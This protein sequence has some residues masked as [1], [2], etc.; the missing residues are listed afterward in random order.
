MNTRLNNIFNKTSNDERITTEDALILYN[1]ADLADLAKMAN[2]IREKKFGK[3]ATF[4]R[5]F[6]IEPTNICIYQC[7]FCSYHRKEGEEGSW[8]LSIDEMVSRA[9]ASGTEQMSEVHIVGAVYKDWDIYF[10][11]NLLKRIRQARPNIHIKAFSAVEISYMCDAV[12]LDLDEGL[13][14][15]KESGLDSIPGGG[16]EIFEPSIRKQICPDKINGEDWLRVHETAHKNGIP[17]NATMLY[18]HIENYSHRVEHMQLL[19]QLQD[20]TKGF[21][22]FIPLKYRNMHNDLSGIK[23]VSIT[24]DF[25]NY[26]IARIFMDNVPHIKAYWPMLGKENAFLSLHYGVDDLDGTID[27][28]TKI[29]EMAG[30]IAKPEMSVDNFIE[31]VKLAGYEPAERDALYGIIQKY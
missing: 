7:K 19:R 2:T 20:K 29:Y 11:S 14:L 8:I 9:L 27:D 4:I 18:G 16:A 21:N 17:T 24:D 31:Q 23:E 3:Q 30:A 22:A 26:A 5:N 12:G 28:S 10:Y 1:E 15:L 6:H 13:L 25:K